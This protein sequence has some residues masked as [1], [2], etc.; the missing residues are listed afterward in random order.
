MII[1]NAGLIG[2]G[3][4]GSVYSRLLHKKYKDNFSA[5]AFGKRKEKI[6]HNGITVNKETFYPK[7]IDCS[8]KQTPLDLVI[9]AVKNYSLDTAIKDLKN[10]IDEHTIL[11]PLL[12]GV[13]ST[14]RLKAAFP[15]NIV[16]YGLSMG[17]DAVRGQDGITNTVDGTIQF[18]F[19]DNRSI[20]PEVTAVQ[21]FLD[22]A[23]IETA[24]FK[25]M[26]RMVWR[27][28]VLNVG[29]N[30]VSA[31]TH[32]TYGEFLK[33]PYIK[34]LIERAMLE[35]VNV[36]KALDINVTEKDVTDINSLMGSFSP[37]GKTSMY[38]DME[39]KRKSEV[40]YFSGTLL[41][42]GEKF[43]VPTPVNEILYKLIK[44]IEAL[45]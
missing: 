5:I 43:N 27:K 29:W 32:A 17:I 37:E 36:A 38:Q 4:V 21:E 40:D 9:I 15:N 7:V 22:E 45:Y 34:E 26:K 16:F 11:L 31:L 8:I 30:Q 2:M 35:V 10:V 12:N 6:E 23:G 25:D 42:L 24:V 41:K 18:G 3:A 39:N 13:T 28:Y 1:A 14:D 19:A 44:S 20:K 33:T